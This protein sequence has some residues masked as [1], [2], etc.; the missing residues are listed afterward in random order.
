MKLLRHGPKGHEK[1]A[2]LDAQGQVRDLSGVIADLRA[3]LDQSVSGPME[4]SLVDI[5]EMDLTQAAIVQVCVCA[6]SVCVCV[7]MS[8][9][10]VRVWG[11]G[12]VRVLVAVE[13]RW[14]VA[15]AV[16]FAI[17]AP[18]QRHD[19]SLAC[20]RIACLSLW[21]DDEHA[22]CCASSKCLGVAHCG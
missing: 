1:P 16:A 13:C 12:V 20:C 8:C 6:H 4:Q 2:L 17:P 7:C 22:H 9:V 5:E 19:A 21:L 15:A 10:C 14:S 18:K 11:E 3:E